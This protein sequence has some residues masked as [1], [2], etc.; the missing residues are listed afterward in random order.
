MAGG[1]GQ[2]EGGQWPKDLHMAPGSAQE[3]LQVGPLRTAAAEV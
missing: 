1:G 2:G 3:L